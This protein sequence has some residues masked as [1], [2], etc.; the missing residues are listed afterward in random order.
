[1]KRT[2]FLL[3]VLG[4]A[5]VFAGCTDMITPEKIQPVSTSV[6]APKLSPSPDASASPI[7]TA[8]ATATPSATATATS[9]AKK[10]K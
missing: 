4:A 8:S 10:T 6:I 9:S 1:M 2:L 5:C 7:A 3:S